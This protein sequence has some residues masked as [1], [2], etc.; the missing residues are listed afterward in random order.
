MFGGR[1]PFRHRRFGQAGDDRAVAISDD[2]RPQSPRAVGVHADLPLADVA[3]QM[4]R[5]DVTTVVVFG[6]DGPL[7]VVTTRDITRAVAAGADVGRA[8]AGDVMTAPDGVDD[9]FWG[10]H[11]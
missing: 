1:S 4:L 8:T 3:R 5:G 11:L 6:P 9:P 7:G 2:N 10:A